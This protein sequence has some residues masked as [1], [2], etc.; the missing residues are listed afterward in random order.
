MA[1]RRGS[2]NANASSPSSDRRLHCRSSELACRPSCSPCVAVADDCRLRRR[3]ARLCSAAATSWASRIA[4]TSGCSS[5][6]ATR[7]RESLR[8]SRLLPSCFLMSVPRI[9]RLPDRATADGKADLCCAVLDGGPRKNDP[10][11]GRATGANR[12][13][14]D[15]MVGRRDNLVAPVGRRGRHTI[16]PESDNDLVAVSAQAQVTQS[17]KM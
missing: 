6:R 8:A 14:R 3:R 11:G 4:R 12:G 16:L 9:A 7:S 13:V 10:P 15:R 1:G 2:R 5:A 17:V